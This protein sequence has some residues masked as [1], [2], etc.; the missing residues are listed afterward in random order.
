MFRI[1]ELHHCVDILNF[2]EKRLMSQEELVKIKPGAV[3]EARV[4]NE[5]T[6][7]LLVLHRGYIAEKSRNIL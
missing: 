5:S 3:A 7:T 1:E 6:P 2:R 4:G